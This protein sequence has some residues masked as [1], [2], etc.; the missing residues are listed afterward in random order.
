MKTEYRESNW[1]TRASSRSVEEESINW[2]ERKRA[3][4]LLQRQQEK[5]EE[6]E[7]ERHDAD[8]KGEEEMM[9]KAAGLASRRPRCNSKR[10][11]LPA[12]NQTSP[13]APVQRRTL[14]LSSACLVVVVAAVVVVLPRII[15]SFT[16]GL[17][18]WDDVA[19]GGGGDRGERKSTTPHHC[20]S[21]FPHSVL[22]SLKCRREFH[23]NTKRKRSRKGGPPL[24]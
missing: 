21:C 12:G 3:V 14:S 5:H 9:M 7:K 24:H 22:L 8:C 20:R 19:G 18:Q 6:E 2:V 4:I 10:F 13:R 23:D 15:F 16:P 11:A 17:A 1:E